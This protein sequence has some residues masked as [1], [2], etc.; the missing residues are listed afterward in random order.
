MGHF[1]VKPSW[2]SEW[3]Y[4]LFQFGKILSGI[5]NVCSICRYDVLEWR[6]M[7]SACVNADAGISA[8]W[9]APNA[10][11][12]V[13]AWV[14]VHLSSWSLNGGA[15]YF[16]T[17]T[18][19]PVFSRRDKSDKSHPPSRAPSCWHSSLLKQLHQHS[20]HN[21]YII[22]ICLFPPYRALLDSE[23][24]KGDKTL[25]EEP[26]NFPMRGKWHNPMSE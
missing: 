25:L 9:A 22:L 21:I 2:I 11:V 26:R 20:S 18:T 13:D 24:L 23:S 5:T 16:I 3:Y 8:A 10:I 17:I 12:C 6:Q 14:C 4:C 19:H 1:T 15:F 7:W